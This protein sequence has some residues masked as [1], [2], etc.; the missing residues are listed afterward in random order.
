[1]AKKQLSIYLSQD[2]INIID[3]Y[4]DEYKLKNRTVAIE[5]IILEWE[6]LKTMPI[7]IGNS[8]I[9]I[10]DYKKTEKDVQKEMIDA[11][12]DDIYNF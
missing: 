1:M 11:E 9:E 7:T 8:N 12:L 10:K 6:M 2:I 4:K 3:N 5:R